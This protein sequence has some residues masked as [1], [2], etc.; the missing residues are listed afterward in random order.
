ML[1][2][3]K[4]LIIFDVNKTLPCNC[5][6]C[7]IKWSVF[8][9][10]VL[11]TF[12]CNTLPV[13]PFLILYRLFIYYLFSHVKVIKHNTKNKVCFKL[14]AHLFQNI[15]V[16]TFPMGS[17]AILKSSH[18]GFFGL[19]VFGPDVTF[20]FED[21]VTQYLIITSFYNPYIASHSNCTVLF[22]I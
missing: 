2:V 4:W 9:L 6:T 16:Y 22:V 13:T 12:S 5:F 21:S 7:Y 8:Y 11:Y 3:L 15:L 10:P 18:G 19:A 17:Y 1:K 20:K 14:P